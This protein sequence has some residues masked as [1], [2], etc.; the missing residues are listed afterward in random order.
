MREIT[1]SLRKLQIEPGEPLRYF[2]TLSQQKTVPLNGLLGRRIELA[3]DTQITCVYC[4]RK[5]KKSFNQG[6]CFVC[7]RKLARCDQCMLKPEQCH[8]HLGTCREPDWA[9]TVCMQKH[10]VYLSFTSSVKVGITRRTNMPYRWFDQG[11]TL[12]LPIYEVKS[13]RQSGLV[14]VALKEYFAD[15]TQWRQM[16][17]EDHYDSDL[18]QIFTMQNPWPKEKWPGYEESMPAPQRIAS[19]DK[20][21]IFHYPR[22]ELPSTIRSHNPEKTPIIQG[23]LI[24]MKGQYLLFDT[25]VINIRKYTGYTVT[26]RF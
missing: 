24:G 25:G 5:T 11:A 15:K 3:F 1:G 4:N 14:E 13:R 2:F 10:I 19:V 17:K 6:Y 8:F 18:M 26:L 7:F 12:A 23:T 16:L 9:E 20:K 21:Q 22:I